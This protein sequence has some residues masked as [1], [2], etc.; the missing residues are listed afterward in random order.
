MTFSSPQKKILVVDDH[1]YIVD[2]LCEFLES[3]GYVC[4]PCHSSR[5][6]IQLFH[7]DPAI[8]LVLCDLLM[9]E[10]DG[11]ELVQALRQIAGKTRVFEAI[12]LTGYGDKQDVIRALREGFSDYFQKPVDLNELLAGLKR[13]EKA[14]LE[15][16]TSTQHLG[17]LSQKLY[18]LIDSINDLSQDIGNTHL[19]N[20]STTMLT[21]RGKSYTEAAPPSFDQL[22]P[23]Q[24]QVAQLVSTGQ[25]NFQIACEMGI[26]ENTVKLY[27]SQVLRLTETKNRTQLALALTPGHSKT[28]QRSSAY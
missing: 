1:P 12:M 5:Q 22:S 21:N 9:P 2:E 18:T 13:R 17:D 10:Y 3:S 16:Q 6:A 11:V 4:I 15:R 28:S 20:A 7:D 26:T 14:L 24:L 27:V 25:T 8:N 19:A 23:R